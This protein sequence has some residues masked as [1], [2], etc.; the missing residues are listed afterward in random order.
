MAT[1]STSFSSLTLPE[2]I[3]LSPHN[4]TKR[5]KLSLFGPI[6]LEPRRTVKIPGTRIKAI[7]REENA[8]LEEKDRELVT[9][10]NGS[11]NGSTNGYYNYGNSSVDNYGNGTVKVESADENLLKYVNGNGNGN[12]SV[13]VRSEEEVLETVKMEEVISKKKSVEEIGQEEA[14]F[15]QSG[16]DQVEVYCCIY[17]LLC[18]NLL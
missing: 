18:S 7:Q 14:W 3:F 15:K 11:V 2:L 1:F 8:V 13:T 16:Q 9:K 17:I 5:L 12:G 10:L 6:N 4:P